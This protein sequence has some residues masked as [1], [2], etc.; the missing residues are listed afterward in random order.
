[1]DF[2]QPNQE[3]MMLK[4]LKKDVPYSLRQVTNEEGQDRQSVRGCRVCSK[5]HGAWVCPDF[6][7]RIYKGGGTVLNSVNCVSVV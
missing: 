1:M 6:N 2:Q 4:K 3:G 7:S 5:P